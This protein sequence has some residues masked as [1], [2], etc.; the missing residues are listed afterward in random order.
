[1]IPHFNVKSPRKLRE[2][3]ELKIDSHCM[4]LFG[5]SFL[6]ACKNKDANKIVYM[7][8]VALEKMNIREHG[9][10]NRGKLVGLIQAVIGAFF[11]SGD[12]LAWC[13]SAVQ[14]CV[15]YAERKTGI[16]SK[17]Y[18]SESCASVRGKSPVSLLV[19]VKDSRLGDVWVWVYT[20]GSRK[21]LGHTGIF[22][23][24]LSSDVAQMYEG[25]TES[26]M[27]GGKVERD[28][29]GFY[30]TQRPIKIK[31]MKVAAVIRAFP[32][33]LKAAA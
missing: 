9:G 2:E 22:G 15:A 31:G 12:G 25:N 21:G 29:G 19:D 7:A 10:N 4:D 1:M 24:W 32:E 18:A 26:G 27:V 13:M 33:T 23:G 5:N 6:E 14:I 30:Q 3:L 16:V 20:E 8:A 11:P 28:G 17:M